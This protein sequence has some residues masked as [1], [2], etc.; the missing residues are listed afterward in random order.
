MTSKFY[1]GNDKKLQ[2]GEVWYSSQDKCDKGVVITRT[3]RYGESE[4]DVSIFYKSTNKH[5]Y[6]IYDKSAWD[7]QVRYTHS[8]DRFK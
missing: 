7:F 6:Y 1:S 3:E 2:V 4:H 8:S 5:S